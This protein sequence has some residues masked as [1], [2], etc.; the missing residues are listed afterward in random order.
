MDALETEL[1]EQINAVAA[2]LD[3]SVSVQAAALSRAG[4][5]LVGD[6]NEAVRGVVQRY[7]EDAFAQLEAAVGPLRTAVESLEA[8]CD[9]SET[10]VV[11]RCGEI[12]ARLKAASD[13]LA[14]MKPALDLA[15]QIQ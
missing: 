6:H 1:E 4:E 3:Q 8:A 15:G 13:L 10:V 5:K 11:D 12:T 2:A 7:T 14:R 9:G